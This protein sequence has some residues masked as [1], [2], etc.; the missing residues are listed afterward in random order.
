MSWLETSKVLDKWKA[1]ADCSGGVKG[2]EFVEAA[3]AIITIFDLINGMGI[4]KGD[5]E[6]NATTL[7]KNLKEGQT[8]EACVEAELAAGN[9]KKLVGDGKTSTC[10]LLWLVRALYFIHGLLKA[11]I[12]DKDKTLKDC[13][14]A[15]YE[16]SLKPHHGFVTKNIFAVAVKAAPSREAFIAKVGESNE[17]VMTAFQEVMPM[18]ESTIQTLHNFLKAKEIETK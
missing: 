8:V 4:P 12:E 3:Q 1:L 9:L 10:A 17:Q 18:Y 11:L 6:G 15:G 2:K 16:T 7:G 14:L 5:M 13:V